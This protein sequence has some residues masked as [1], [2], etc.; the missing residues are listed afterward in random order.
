V[1]SEF[2]VRIPLHSRVDFRGKD[3][4]R[5]LQG[6]A[7]GAEGSG[8]RGWGTKGRVGKMDR[9]GQFKIYSGGTFSEVE[10]TGYAD[11][12]DVGSG[13]NRRKTGW[14]KFFILITNQ[15]VI[16]LLRGKTNFGGG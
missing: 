13:G 16:L 6:A 4:N 3:R 14:F 12:F 9:S 2:C 11:G 15:V 10:L 1:A 7:A 8:D 5:R